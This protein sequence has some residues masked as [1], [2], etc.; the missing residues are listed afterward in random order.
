MYSV[1]NCY[2]YA[3]IQ[4]MQDIT[5]VVCV[6]SNV[7][8]S[9]EHCNDPIPYGDGADIGEWINH[10]LGHGYKLLHIGTDYGFGDVPNTVAVLG[11]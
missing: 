6:A 3:R 11:K 9:C 8:K 2:D 5:H 4:T 7:K 1:G 10:Y